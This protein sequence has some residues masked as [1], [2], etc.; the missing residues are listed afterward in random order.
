[1]AVAPRARHR[2]APV[3][4]TLRPTKYCRSS[5]V[6]S[7]MRRASSRRSHT[8]PLSV[9]G[10]GH[11]HA[12]RFE[13]PA[14][15]GRSST[16]RP[17]TSHRSRGRGRRVSVKLS[18]DETRRRIASTPDLHVCGG[19]DPTRGSPMLRPRNSRPQMIDTGLD[20]DRIASCKRS[21]PAPQAARPAPK[22]GW[23][24]LQ[25]DRIRSLQRGTPGP[26]ASDVTPPH[27]GSPR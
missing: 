7:P 13:L 10:R 16:S 5:T 3:R 23:P 26:I 22:A 21:C 18:H 2:P 4:G 11:L 1:M 12:W 20:H 8:G 24:V 27:V 25:D 17:V 6:A 14:N 15:R 9:V 19:E